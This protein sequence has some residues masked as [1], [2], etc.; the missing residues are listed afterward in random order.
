VVARGLKSKIAINVATLLLLSALVTDILIVVVTQT[1]MTRNAV[2]KSQAVMEHLGQAYFSSFPDADSPA[3]APK[4]GD[5]LLD[6]FKGHFSALGVWN[7]AGRQLFLHQVPPYTLSLS[8][9]QIETALAAKRPKISDLGM[10]WSIFWW[11]SNATAITAPVLIQAEAVGVVAAIVSFNPLLDQLR[12]YHKAIL[13]YIVINTCILTIIGLYRIFRLYLS[14]IDRIVSQADHFNDDDDPFFAFRQEDNELNRLSLSLNRM[15]ARISSDKKKLHQTVSSLETANRELQVAQREIIKAEK[16]A[17]VGRLAAGIAHEIGNPIGIVF[18][19]LDLLKQDDLNEAEKDDFLKRIEV[20][21]QRINSIIRQLLDLARTKEIKP[22]PMALHPVIEDIVKVMAVQPLTTDIDI[23]AMLAADKDMVWGNEDQ[24]RQVF[25]N[26]LLNAAD[27]IR[28]GPDPASGTI[29][30][31]TANVDNEGDSSSIDITVSD[32]GPGI[33]AQQLGN[34]FDPFYTTK[35]PGKGTGLGLAVS[36][37]IIDGLGGRISANRLPQG[38]AAF[39]ISLRCAD[40]GSTAT[41]QAE[42]VD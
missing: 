23:Q 26:L 9:G 13:L 2:V 38:G 24:L 17:S 7:K 29:V 40:A 5:H 32:N 35:E 30:V 10:T 42:S 22:R 21:V 12:G 6:T 33:D 8:Q 39:T 37:M 36:Y 41:Q 15:L 28:S 11:H 31:S 19:Y 4:G 34:I 16:L 1:I 3:A 25:L 27:A 18:G 20:E 14:P